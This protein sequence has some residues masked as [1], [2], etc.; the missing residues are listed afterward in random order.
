MPLTE[1]INIVSKTEN[2]NELTLEIRKLKDKYRNVL[3]LHYIQGL[4]IYEIAE[5]L[6]IT[7]VNVRKRLE[8][9][10]NMIKENIRREEKI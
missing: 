7:E 2:E 10:R 5:I 3:E 1:N 9:G 4:E 6:K 8:R